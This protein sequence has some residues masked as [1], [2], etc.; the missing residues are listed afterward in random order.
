MAQINPLFPLLAIG[1]GALALGG[2]S[3]GGS[4][5]SRFDPLSGGTGGGA[6]EDDEG[7]EDLYEPDPTFYPDGPS[8]LPEEAPDLDPGLWD[9]ERVLPGDGNVL[10]PMIVGFP[11]E[12]EVAVAL[13]ELDQFLSDH[14]VGAYT[15]AYELTRMPKAPG[16]PVAVPHYSLWENIIPTLWIWDQIREEVGV[17]MALRGYRPKDYNLATGGVPRSLHQWFSA[18]D[19]RISGADNTSA[20]RLALAL[21]AARYYKEFGSEYDIGFI[22]YG[23]PVP[24]NIHLDTGWKKRTWEDADVYVDQV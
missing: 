24:G 6:L 8:Q 19:I 21:A 13:E 18:I 5:G 4:R 2:S 12:P 7:E 17:P 23:D 16:Q 20:N 14:N 9:V 15:D 11:D 10:P 3:G 22:A 1:L